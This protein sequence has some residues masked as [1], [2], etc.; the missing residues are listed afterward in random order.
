VVWGHSHC[1]AGK[2]VEY[3][4]CIQWYHALHSWPQSRDR[5]HAECPPPASMVHIC[6]EKG[7]SRNE[8]QKLHTRAALGPALGP[9]SPVLAQTFGG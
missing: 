9:E 8:A 4:V 5:R 7:G 3:G 2:P 1:P 6:S